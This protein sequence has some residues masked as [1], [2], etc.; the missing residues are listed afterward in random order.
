[1]C[2]VGTGAWCF[3]QLV[4]PHQMK[5]ALA[6]LKTQY[7]RRNSKYVVN[8]NSQIVICFAFVFAQKVASLP[9][10]QHVPCF[11]LHLPHFALLVFPSP[12][13]T[14]CLGSF[15]FGHSC[16]VPNQPCGAPTEY[17]L[18]PGQQ[19]PA[20]GW[21]ASHGEIWDR[22]LVQVGFPLCLISGKVKVKRFRGS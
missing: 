6:F 22:C 14:T 20:R 10:P 18:L 13:Q 15:N 2:G 17:P 9:A 1:M 4:F 21:G 16:N 11:L 12:S 5:N 3:F 8:R 7:W 19:Q